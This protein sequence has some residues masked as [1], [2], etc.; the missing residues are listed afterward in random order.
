MITL[1]LSASV[2]LDDA[3]TKVEHDADAVSAV[4]SEPSFKVSC[5]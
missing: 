1:I 3:D 2:L 4:T 5:K